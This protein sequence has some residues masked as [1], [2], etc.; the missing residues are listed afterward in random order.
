ML[1]GVKSRAIWA[2]CG[3]NFGNFP[4]RRPCPRLPPPRLPGI[5][6]L[7]RQSHAIHSVIPPPSTPSFP[8]KRESTRSQSS[9]PSRNQAQIATSG[10]LLPSWEKARMRVSP[11]ASA[12]LRARRP[13]SHVCQTFLC[14]PILPP[15]IP[16]KAGIHRLANSLAVRNQAPSVDSGSLL[17]SWEKARM[18]VRRAQARRCGR[19]ARA[20]MYAKPSSVSLF[21]PSSFPQKRESRCP[22]SS[23]PSRNQ[24]QIAAIGSLLPSWAYK[25]RF[26]PMGARASR[27][28]SRACARL[29]LTLA[30]SHKRLTGV[31]SK[32][33][34]LAKVGAPG[35]RGASESDPQPEI[36]Y[37]LKPSDPFSLYGRRLG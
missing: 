29:T 4:R 30:L 21:S 12:A 5:A 35:G 23:S 7:P 37:E 22:Q 25:G 1:D 27:P 6:I 19:D 9:P 17:P 24:A 2:F 10:S 31:V 15:V 34:F 36:K 8:R 18:R 28:Q 16:A 14:K 33:D 26:A 11:R 20:P 3:L 32:F 13:R